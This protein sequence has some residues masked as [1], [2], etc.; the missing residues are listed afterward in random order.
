[1]PVIPSE[2]NDRAA[3]IW[4]PLLAIAD[5][6]GGEWP[7]MARQAAVTLSAGT[8]EHT[9]IEHLLAD[10]L[11]VFK[12]ANAERL[13]SR[14]IVAGLNAMTDRG[15]AELT[16]GR[17]FSSERGNVQGRWLSQQLRPYG[18]GPRAMRLGEEVG[19]GYE[20][21]EIEEAACRYA[22]RREA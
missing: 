4:E 18:I 22:T 11:S 5:A 2:L 10:I 13:F 6:A 1:M 20:R 7:E 16:G 14:E 9:P 19:K 12:A 17:G 21:E 3:D 8:E 15:W